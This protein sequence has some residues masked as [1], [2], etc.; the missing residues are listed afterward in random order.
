MISYAALVLA[1]A[2]WGLA[3]VAQRKGLE[4]LDPF[5]FNALRFALGAGCVWLLDLAN[6]SLSRKKKLRSDYQPDFPSVT[7]NLDRPLILGLLLFSASSLQQVGMLWTGAGQAGF[8]TGLYVVI[9]PLIGLWK[10]QKMTRTMVLAVFLSVAGMYLMNHSQTPKATWGNLLVLIGALFWALHVR[11]IDRLAKL[12]PSLKLAWS[13]YLV[14]AVCSLAG[15]LIWRFLRL[16]GPDMFS[17]LPQQIRSAILPILYAGVMSV[18]V[19][20]TLQLFAQKR[21]PPVPAS[22]I[23]CSEGVFAMLGGWLLLSESL[24]TRALAGA[25]LLLCAMLVS[26]LGGRMGIF[27]I[28]KK[29]ASQN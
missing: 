23:L 10:G 9:V 12:H 4:S 20:F 18:G 2:I 14:C 3:F 28:D 16:G 22:V 1:A 19:A 27:L 6:K 26:V 21:V 24:T 8:I 15:A 11:M 7:R 17:A 25:V 13:Q 29:R 5:T